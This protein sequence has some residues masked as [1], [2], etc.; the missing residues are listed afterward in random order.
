[1]QGIKDHDELREPLRHTEDTENTHASTHFLDDLIKSG[2]RSAEEIR[3]H[4]IYIRPARLSNVLERS[5]Q[6]TGDSETQMDR[7]T[8]SDSEVTQLNRMS[9]S[10]SDAGTV[11]N[12]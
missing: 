1:M 7:M 6:Y 5:G 2:A 10:M 11:I 3:Q 4:S 9:A 8:V 12:R